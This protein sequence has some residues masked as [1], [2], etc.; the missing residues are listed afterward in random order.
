MTS[1]CK[2]VTFSSRSSGPGGGG[3]QKGR[4]EVFEKEER[5]GEKNFFGERGISLGTFRGRGGRGVGG[6]F[7]QAKGVEVEAQEDRELSLF[8][9]LFQTLFH[10]VVCVGGWGWRG[11]WVGER[12]MWGKEVVEN[13]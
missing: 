9:L 7:C 4:G 5:G 1:D 3:R 13:A 10:P 11:G 12:W 8:L 2:G 6:V